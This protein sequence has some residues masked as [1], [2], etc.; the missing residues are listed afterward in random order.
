MVTG[1]AL[2]PQAH[3]PTCKAAQLHEDVTCVCH[4]QLLAAC[5]YVSPTSVT[6]FSKHGVHH[7]TP[8]TRRC[9]HLLLC[10][11]LLLFAV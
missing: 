6:G 1:R 5:V 8:C 10:S 4:T 7:P 2:P 9:L 11:A 3:E